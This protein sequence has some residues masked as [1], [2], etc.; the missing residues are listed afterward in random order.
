MGPGSTT[1]P[2]GAMA[3][4]GESS[5]MSSGAHTTVSGMSMSAAHGATNILPNWLAI[6]WTVVFVAIFVIHLLH[7]RDTHGQRR[8]WHSGHVLMAAG[9]VFM[10]APSS[11]DHF[12]IPA[13]FWQLAFANAAGLMIAWVIFQMLSGRAVNLL[14]IVIAIDL[15]AMVYMWS[16]NGFVAPV[17]WLLVAYFAIQ[18]LAWA[19]NTFRRLDREHQIPG[20]SR[21]SI[22][23]G[24]TATISVAAHAEPLVCELDLRPSMA[25]MGLGMAYMF[26]AMQLLS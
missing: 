4:G 9:M 22:N 2:S 12:N 26:A 1:T 6:V 15:G 23:P 19:T 11:I 14:W 10:F 18:S 20:I 24:G 3:M 16:P 13:T 21:I 25:L 7:V 17:T 8:L 5:G